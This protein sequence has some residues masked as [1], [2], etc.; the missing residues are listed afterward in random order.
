M[1]ILRTIKVGSLGGRSSFHDEHQLNNMLNSV[2]RGKPQLDRCWLYVYMGDAL[3]LSGSPVKAQDAYEMAMFD[4]V[5][6]L[7]FAK[8]FNKSSSTTMQLCICAQ[9]QRWGKRLR[10]NNL[11]TAKGFSSTKPSLFGCYCKLYTPFNF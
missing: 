5:M 10:G 6:W 1:L 4:E 3:R 8:Y 9:W 11:R 7:K 2:V